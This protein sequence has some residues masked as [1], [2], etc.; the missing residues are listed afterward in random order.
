MIGPIYKIN[1]F[2][3]VSKKETSSSV[4][5]EELKNIITQLETDIEDITCFHNDYSSMDVKFMPALI[6]QENK[7][8]PEM[9]LNLVLLHETFLQK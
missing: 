4:S 7:K 6:I 2:N 1:R 8:Y 5:N 9:N 3:D